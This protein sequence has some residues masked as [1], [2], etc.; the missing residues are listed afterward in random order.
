MMDIVFAH[1]PRRDT[2]VVVSW[3]DRYVFR[4]DS[5]N[6]RFVFHS[7]L[8][9]RGCDNTDRLA[10]RPDD[11]DRMNLVPIHNVAH[12]SDFLVWLR[13][14][15]AFFHQICNLNRHPDHS[16]IRF[17][18]GALDWARIS[19]RVLLRLVVINNFLFALCQRIDR[20]NPLSFQLSDREKDWLVKSNFSRQSE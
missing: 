10:Y 1:D 19:L 2:G 5:A 14:Y 17:F 3:H 13:C 9:V 8:Y 7:A 12:M 11:R 4:H 20:D 16:L 6:W 18:Q 15:D